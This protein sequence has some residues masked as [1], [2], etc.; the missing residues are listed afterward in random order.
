MFFHKCR[1]LLKK[2]THEF[3]YT[4]MLFQTFADSLRLFLNIKVQAKIHL[5]LI[6]VILLTL[7]ASPL[8]GSPN[9]L[10]SVASL[11]K[12]SLSHHAYL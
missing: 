12:S 4:E 7:F 2:L 10:N 1:Q 5:F 11:L 8:V 6:T 9:C 3:Q